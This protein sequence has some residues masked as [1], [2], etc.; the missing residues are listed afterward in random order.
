MRRQIPD[1]ALLKGNYPGH[2]CQWE[3]CEDIYAI[4]IHQGKYEHYYDIRNSLRMDLGSNDENNFAQ[5][6][7]P[8]CGSSKGV[9]ERRGISGSN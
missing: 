1:Q 9:A 3:R 2:T 5:K 6:I 8:I 4:R 7:R